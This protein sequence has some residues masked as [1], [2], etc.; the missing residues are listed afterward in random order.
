L[1]IQSESALIDASKERIE[2]PDEVR[3]EQ[4]ERWVTGRQLVLDQA[5]KQLRL[6]ARVQAFFP[7]SPNES[8][9]AGRE[10]P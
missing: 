7:A 1:Q 6:G 2:L 4:G 3:I 9:H 10:K 5:E 8:L